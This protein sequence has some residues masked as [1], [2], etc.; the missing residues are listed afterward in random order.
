MLPCHP[1]EGEQMGKIKERK[2]A[3]EKEFISF[4]YIAADAINMLLYAGTVS[5]TDDFG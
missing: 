1:M 5:E 4:P 2:D 3:V